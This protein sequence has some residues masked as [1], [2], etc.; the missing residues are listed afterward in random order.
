MHWIKISLI[1]SAHG[2]GINT[3][4]LE[5]NIINLAVV[6]TIVFSFV[7]DALK[8]L[9][10]ARKKNILQNICAVN[11]RA[12]E[13]EQKMKD[14]IMQL[15]IAKKKAFEIREQGFTS[16]E[17][18]KKNYI[19]QTEEEAQRLK[20]VKLDTIRLIQQKAIEQISQQ[21]IVF[22]LKQVRE[23]LKIKMKSRTFQPWVNQIKV[24]KYT[25]VKLFSKAS[26]I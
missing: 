11:D 12:Q 14:A 25:S 17:R 2:F 7:G 23:K 15:E 3:N 26:I 24:K 19:E 9:L 16:A 4:I 10:I 1:F 21:I 8:D 18:E 22:S 5:T 6:I 13:I 20:Q